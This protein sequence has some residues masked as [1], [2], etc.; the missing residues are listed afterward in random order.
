[1]TTDWAFWATILVGLET[2]KTELVEVHPVPREPAILV[3]TSNQ[4]RAV[5]LLHGTRTRV[6]S[7]SRVA[8]PLTERW[9]RAGSALVEELSVDSDVYAFSYAQ[10]APVREIARAPGLLGAIEKLRK[11]GYTEI[12]LLGHSAGGVIA[13][14]LVEDSP[15]CGVTKVIQVFSP[16]DGSGWAHLS[17]AARKSQRP[18]LESLRQASCRE[19]RLGCRIPEKVAFVC[20]IGDLLGIG[21][22]IVSDVS[23]WPEDLRRQG[24]PAVC[25]RATHAAIRSRSAARTLAGLVREPPQRRWSAKRVAEAEKAFLSRP[26]AKS[27]SGWLRRAARIGN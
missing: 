13:R 16:N 12:V 7:A 22:G 25:L 23:Q 5:V 19:R 10:T 27:L 20:V 17:W 11:L 2:V 14:H 3:R 4:A 18:F 26:V 15:D 6:F 8:M 9:Q 24:V 1:M 21:D